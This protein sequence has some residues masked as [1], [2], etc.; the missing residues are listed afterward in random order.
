MKAVG[1]RFTLEERKYAMD[2]AVARRED[3]RRGWPVRLFNGDIMTFEPEDYTYFLDRVATSRKRLIEGLSELSPFADDA[4]TVAEQMSDL[5][6]SRFR[7][8]LAKER[9]RAGDPRI[10]G[11]FPAKWQCILLPAAFIQA[12]PARIQY[13]APLGCVLIKLAEIERDKDPG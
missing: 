4:L 11:I 9:Q 12:A 2:E 13:G 10:S 8:A 6:F 3:Y 1:K 7:Q 5:D